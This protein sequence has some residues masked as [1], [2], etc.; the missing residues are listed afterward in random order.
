MQANVWLS[1]YSTLW[2]PRAWICGC[3]YS[4]RIKKKPRQGLLILKV[5]FA[6][7]LCQM[8]EGWEGHTWNIRQSWGI[9]WVSA[10]DL[11][12]L[13]EWHESFERDHKEASWKVSFCLKRINWLVYQWTN[14][15]I[16]GR[17]EKLYWQTAFVIKEVYRVLKQNTRKTIWRKTQTLNFFIEQQWRACW[18]T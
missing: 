12:P 11:N 8:M 18:V 7:V 17:A 3:P 1:C 2:R 16:E 15:I 9:K 13:G 10:R 4:S 14:V 6:P 5:P